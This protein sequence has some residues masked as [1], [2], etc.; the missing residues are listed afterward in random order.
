[1]NSFD[2]SLYC[3]LEDLAREI[4]HRA[5]GRDVSFE[6]TNWICVGLATKEKM[7]DLL[8]T[9]ITLFDAPVGEGGPSL[10][11]DPLYEA[12]YRR[13]VRLIQLLLKHHAKVELKSILFV[14]GTWRVDK[15]LLDTLVGRYGETRLLESQTQTL[16]HAVRR[17]PIDCFLKYWDLPRFNWC[18][19]PES[20]PL[21]DNLAQPLK[22]ACGFGFYEIVEYVLKFRV[23]PIDPRLR[24]LVDDTPAMAEALINGEV[25]VAH[26]FWVY[27]K[28]E[29]IKSKKLKEMVR[30]S[31]L[32][33]FKK[34]VFAYLDKQSANR[35]R[36]MAK[37]RQQEE[38]LEEPSRKKARIEEETGRIS[39]TCNI[40]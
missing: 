22:T 1:M 20:E 15:E 31:V 32:P 4:L 29:F 40:L 9:L 7:T 18:I 36:I 3:G 34:D 23:I 33:V 26:L 8:E 28:F 17:L 30:E 35:K 37:K 12:I 24:S 14:A 19:Q 25:K 11:P 39:W 38:Y 2:I 16:D 6:D 27:G 13:E 21:V 5:G 10:N